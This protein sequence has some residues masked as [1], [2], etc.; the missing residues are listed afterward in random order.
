MVTIVTRHQQN[1]KYYRKP[2]TTN[3]NKL[4]E[5]V[6]GGYIISWNGFVESDIPALAARRSSKSLLHS[7]RS[8][9]SKLWFARPHS[10]SRGSIVLSWGQWA[11][12]DC[13]D[14]RLVWSAPLEPMRVLVLSTTTQTLTQ[15]LVYPKPAYI[16]V[17]IW[18]VVTNSHCN[19]L[20]FDKWLP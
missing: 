12:R 13:S 4:Q 16:M 20:F 8:F 3:D 1:E 7:T 11:V 10:L 5:N 15:Y 17:T 2:N 9:A 6:N 14:D 18:Q 19:H